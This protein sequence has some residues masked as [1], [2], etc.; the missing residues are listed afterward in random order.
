[1]SFV[2]SPGS[3]AA[4]LTELW[5]PRVVAE[6]DD[7]YV[8]VAKV[9]GSL[10]WHSHDNEDELFFVLK[11][12]LRI[13]MDGQTVELDE[14]E[15]S[16][17]PKGVRHNPVA[18]EECHLLLIERKSTQHTGNVTTEKTRSLAEQLRPMV[19]AGSSGG[20][21]Q[22]RRMNRARHVGIVAVSAEGAALCYRTLCAESRA[23]LGPHDHPQVTMHTFPLAEYMVHVAAG[24]WQDAAGLLLS[25]ADVLVRAGAELLVCP[26]NTLHQALDLVRDR[27]PVPWLHIAEEVAAVALASGFKRLGIL[28]T[29]YLME[30]PVYRRA[31]VAAGIGHEIPGADDRERINAIIFDE[32]VYGRL[33]EASR[34]YFRAVIEALGARGCDA[35]VLGCTEIPLLITETDSPLPVIDSTRTLA[36][37]AIREATRRGEGAHHVSG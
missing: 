11:G 30:G 3:L 23:I 37:A 36:R 21:A 15:L 2:T 14:G 29:R 12:H 27:T 26:D 33:E 34:S 18:D 16:V 22:T 24:R 13:E 25:S 10:A 31:L 6:V 35:V 20:L 4:S 5:S 8:K 28:G 19:S 9:H 17:V 7:A 32:L 1:V